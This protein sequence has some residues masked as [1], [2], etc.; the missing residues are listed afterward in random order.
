MNRWIKMDTPPAE[1]FPCF[2]KTQ[3]RNSVAM[4]CDGD[5]YTLEYDPHLGVLRK[6][7][8]HGVT[9]YTLCTPPLDENEENYS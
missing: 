2:V 3:N 7:P 4:F 6:V 1:G 5:W 8:V 9:A